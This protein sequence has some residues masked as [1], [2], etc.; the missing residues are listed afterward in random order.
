M[1]EIGCF[2][3]VAEII[4]GSLLYVVVWVLFSVDSVSFQSFILRYL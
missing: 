1:T 3:G 4:V 2:L